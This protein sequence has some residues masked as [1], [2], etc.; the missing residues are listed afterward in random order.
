MLLLLINFY[1]NNQVG[2]LINL[3]FPAPELRE[4]FVSLYYMQMMQ[5]YYLG[6]L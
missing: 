1:I 5:L 6:L 4:K 2:Y 3:D